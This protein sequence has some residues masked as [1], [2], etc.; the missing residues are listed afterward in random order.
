M[1]D[2]MITFAKMVISQGVAP[3]LT[4]A[5]FHTAIQ[6]RAEAGRLPGET[7]EQAY[8]RFIL[9]NPDG[10]LLFKA[11][12]AAPK[13]VASAAPADENQ[14][15]VT[16]GPAEKEMHIAVENHRAAAAAQGQTLTPAQAFTAVYTSP[17]HRGLKAR[18][19]AETAASAAKRAAGM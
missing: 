4:A 16:R 10:R 11:Y 18:Y 17:A 9:D 3:G 12:R 13:P 8:T 14:D 6:K 1:K 19:D 5:D 2:N 7:A 15:Y